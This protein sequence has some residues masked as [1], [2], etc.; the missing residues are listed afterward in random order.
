MSAERSAVAGGCARL[1]HHE[2]TQVCERHGVRLVEMGQL[3]LRRPS[4]R[5]ASPSCGAETCPAEE[6]RLVRAAQRRDNRWH[7]DGDH[8]GDEAGHAA[9]RCRV[10]QGRSPKG[11]AP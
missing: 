4:D 5:A 2:G 7:D 6:Q 3:E 11:I 10:Q 8:I 1:Q 9:P